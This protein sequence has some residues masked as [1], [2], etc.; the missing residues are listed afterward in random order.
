MKEKIKQV[1]AESAIYALGY[2]L[3]TAGEGLQSAIN[4]KK[5]EEVGLLAID[6]NKLTTAIDYNAELRMQQLKK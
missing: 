2:F 4:D 6:V 1:L 3:K 5:A